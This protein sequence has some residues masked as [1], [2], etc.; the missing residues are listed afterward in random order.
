MG[1][2]AMLTHEQI[3]H[4]CEL[5]RCG[6]NLT[7]DHSEQLTALLD[8]IGSAVSQAERL[9]PFEPD[10]Q[11]AYVARAWDPVAVEYLRL[12]QAVTR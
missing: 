8:A 6:G 1:N 12:A 10:R 11:D 7:A 9:Y 5:F 3:A 4:L 2:C